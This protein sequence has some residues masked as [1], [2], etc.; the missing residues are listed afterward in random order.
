M[1]F[2]VVSIGCCGNPKE[3]HLTQLHGG[4]GTFKENLIEEA[5]EDLG[6]SQAEKSK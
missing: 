3:E 6:G 5:S 1:C 4:G 2:M